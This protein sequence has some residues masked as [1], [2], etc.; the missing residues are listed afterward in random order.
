MQ[1]AGQSNA[2]AVQ[3]DSPLQKKEKKENTKRDT[4]LPG[5]FSVLLSAK[6]VS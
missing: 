3:I 1:T 6:S 4:K 5:T 2:A